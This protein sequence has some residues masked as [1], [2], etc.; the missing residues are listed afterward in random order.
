MATRTA[1]LRKRSFLTEALDELQKA[2]LALLKGGVKSY[3]IDD[4]QLTRLDLS[5]L[6]K[7]MQDIQDELDEVEALLSGTR[8][9]KAFGIVPRD[10]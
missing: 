5:T 2:Y 10:W 4:R 3:Q 7:E 9:R 1:L 8:P 6:W